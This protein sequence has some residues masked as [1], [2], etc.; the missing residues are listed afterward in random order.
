MNATV[1][2][3]KDRP[4]YYVVLDYRDNSGNRKKKWITTDIPIK[5]NNKR[6]TEERRKE[7]LT[8]Y[9]QKNIDLSKEVLFTVFIKQWLENLRPSIEDVTYDT[10]RLIIYNQIVPFFE[11]KKLRVNTKNKSSYRSMPMPTIIISV[12]KKIKAEQA[13]NKLLQPND[14]IN[15]DY[16]FTFIDGKLI[17]PN[18]VTRH[19]K[20]ILV[21]NNL[22]DIRFHDL[23][24]SSA[25]YLLY[26]GFNMKE[27]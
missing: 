7:V 18:Y 26:L 24:H 2:I 13:K 23:R 25:S 14:Y 27:I 8:E 11:P 20:D 15:S 10:Y 12:L 19:F 5:G 1:Q 17:T 4:Y 22:P 16:V 21:K 9:E 6:K 3:K